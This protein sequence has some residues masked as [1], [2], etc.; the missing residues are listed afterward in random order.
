MPFDYLKAGGL[1]QRDPATPLFSLPPPPP[2]SALNA[3]SLLVV[4]SA[5]SYSYTS[6]D[7]DAELSRL[8]GTLRLNPKDSES[9]SQDISMEATQADAAPRGSITSGP[10]CR[11]HTSTTSHHHEGPFG[12]PFLLS[13]HYHIDTYPTTS[14][15]YLDTIFIHRALL[16]ASP[17]DHQGCSRAFSD[18]ARKIDDRQWSPDRDSDR[19]AVT[20]FLGEAMSVARSF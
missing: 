20:A 18:L 2:R 7:A 1:S 15:A 14:G 17:R 3:N 12:C 8:I 5:M 19:E 6:I 16:R 9:P 13:I 10:E 4:M 11:S